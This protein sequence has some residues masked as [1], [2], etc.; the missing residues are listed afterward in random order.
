MERG[1]ERRVGRVRGI[2]I[3]K[4]HAYTYTPRYGHY[5]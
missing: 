3:G 1:G 5:A 2:G 4:L